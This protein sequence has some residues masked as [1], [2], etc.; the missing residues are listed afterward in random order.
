MNFLLNS[1]KGFIRPQ[2]DVVVLTV[3]HEQLIPET[4]KGKC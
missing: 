1:L 2:Q 3:F 4:N